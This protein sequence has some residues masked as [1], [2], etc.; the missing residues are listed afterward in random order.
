MQTLIPDTLIPDLGAIINLRHMLHQHQELSGHEEQTAKRIVHFMEQYQPDEIITGLGGTGVAIIFNGDEEKGPT[1][2]FRCELD[3]VSVAEM[4]S[5][6][7]TS[8]K[9]GIGHLCGHEGH[10]AILTGLASLLHTGKLKRG[11]VI[12]L[13]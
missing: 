2:L 1:L 13:F 12:L 8:T 11:K 9:E 10:M 6:P 7:Y 4:N 5:L 3:A